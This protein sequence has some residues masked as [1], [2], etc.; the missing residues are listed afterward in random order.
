VFASIIQP[1][2]E[3]DPTLEFTKNSYPDFENI[4]VLFNDSNFTAI[5][6]EGKN[7][8]KWIVLISNSDNKTDSK[9]TLKIGDKDFSWTGPIT[10]IK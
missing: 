7:G 2:G 10:I 6:I 8:I 9:H 5:D 1:H 3:F 4:K